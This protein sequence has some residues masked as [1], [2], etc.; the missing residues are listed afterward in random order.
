M[1]KYTLPALVVLN[2][3]A[4]SVVGSR[5]FVTFADVSVQG[6][7]ASCSHAYHQGMADMQNYLLPCL[8]WFIGALVINFGVA[9]V[10][11]VRPGKPE[12]Q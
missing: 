11:S 12:S 1:K 4:L 8:P 10:L 2:L 6:I 5:F 9:V 3:V 7:P